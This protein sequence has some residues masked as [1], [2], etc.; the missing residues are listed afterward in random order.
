MISPSI[1]I[2]RRNEALKLISDELNG[3]EKYAVI[4]SKD[5]KD[6]FVVWCTS[7]QALGKDWETHVILTDN[8]PDDPPKVRV[9][10]A[11]DLFLSNPHVMSD[12]YL[13]VI[14]ESSSINC[15]DPLRLIFYVLGSAIKILQGTE[16]I[17]FQEEFSSYWGR[18]VDE[19]RSCI[20]LDSPQTL[21]SQFSVVFCKNIICIS[22]SI[23]V[24]NRWCSNYIGEDFKLDS[25]DTGILL[26]LDGVLLTSEYPNT[27]YDLI[28]ISSSR[29][30]TIHQL[31]LK[32]IAL[33]IKQGFV[34][35][36][37][38]INGGYALGGVK[39]TGLGLSSFKSLQ[40]GFRSGKVPLKILINRSGDI[41]KGEKVEKYSIKRVDHEW[42]HTRGG[43]GTNYKNRSVLIIGCGSLGGYIAHLISRAG[44]TNIT[45]L[46][47]DRLEWANLGRHILGA[48]SVS[49]WKAEALCNI[50]KQQMPHLNIIGIP[51]DWREALHH[52]NNLFDD[53]S[54]VVSTVADWRCEGP[55]NILSRTVPFP[56]VIYGWLEPYAVAGHCLISIKS[57]GCLSCG[58]NEYGHFKYNVADYQDLTLKREP[59]G[60]THYQQ[61]GPTALL[62][63][64][65]LVSTTIL[66][67][68]NDL[69]Y[70]SKLKTWVSDQDHFIRAK[71]GLSDLWKD[72]IKF[73]GFS[74]V[75][76][77]D[78]DSSIDCNVCI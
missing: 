68:L 77:S 64:A 6:S 26:R 78:W 57:S 39:F 60:C 5:Y 50:L 35:L 1:L 28:K 34:L 76:S 29:D 32:H 59:G 25:V 10:S 41:L 73:E 49:K 47:N 11:S 7:V 65:S 15:F 52:N 69:P 43:D 20:L 14:P 44:V 67:C 53:H 72:K 70:T 42:I 8:F 19:A 17:D 31:I 9:P 2:H 48:E 12:G 30:S 33:S 56:P 46:D 37:Q 62:P 61:Y 24:L 38:E 27:L 21:S 36:S 55:L 58:M 3:N 16:P 54:L 74:K 45:L 51:K 23:D 66:S 4:S 22:S 13:C 40:H 71:A 75:Y 18:C 63:V